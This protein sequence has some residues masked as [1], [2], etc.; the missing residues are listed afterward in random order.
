MEN[1]TWLKTRRLENKLTHDEVAKAS[2]I[3][4]AYYTMIEQGKRR[5]SVHVA[6]SIAVVLDFDW[7]L[8]FDDESHDSLQNNCI[9]CIYVA[10]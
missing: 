8:F 3:K 2:G 1:R 4:R 5:P 6:K 7:V 10:I 9:K